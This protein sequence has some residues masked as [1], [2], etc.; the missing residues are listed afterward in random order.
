MRVLTLI[1]IFLSA[2]FLIAA[3][4]DSAPPTG[5]QAKET[6]VL[7]GMDISHDQGNIDWFQVRK[8]DPKISFVFIKATE[9]I[10][11]VDPRFQKNWNS[12]R[13]AGIIRGAY[14]FFDAKQDPTTQADLFIKTVKKLNRSDLPP[15]LDLESG[16]FSE[17]DEV[18]KSTF[19]KNVFAWLDAVEQALGARPMIYASAS[20]AGEY[21]TDRR[22]RSYGIEV[23]E[24][25]DAA[26]PKMEGAW[27]GK[28]W[29]FWQYSSNGNIKGIG[30]AVDLEKYNGTN[31]DLL[32]YI[33]ASRR[34]M[35]PMTAKKQT[36]KPET[37]TFEKADAVKPQPTK[38]AAEPQAKPTAKKPARQYNLGRVYFPRNFIHS[39][40][41]YQR[42]FY[43]VKVVEIDD[44]LYF[45]VSNRK[46]KQLLFEELAIVLPVKSRN[47]RFKFRT[48]RNM[49]G[50]LEYF[51]VKVITPREH[52][53]AFFY[54]K[55][56]AEEPK[57]TAKPKKKRSRNIVTM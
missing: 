49:L 13:K 41:E 50:G 20:F 19:V 27:K 18:S 33:A 43:H 42:G 31:D 23:A 6:A 46:T 55:R 15:M 9:S 51:R 53:V 28:K 54:S 12:A 10:N 36:P 24:Y 29:S 2:G 39:Q 5:D 11:F 48:Q 40:K 21:L 25:I 3:G 30:D 7:Y 37:E 38:P 14:H 8:N 16:K 4:Q 35:L 22:F 57:A 45:H 34:K 32:A 26:G 44:A 56:G 47:Q 1:M 52:I 17:V